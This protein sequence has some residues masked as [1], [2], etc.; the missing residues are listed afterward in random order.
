MFF[1]FPTY[2]LDKYKD[3]RNVEIQIPSGEKFLTKLAITDQEKTKGLSGTKKEQFA[4]NHALLFFYKE[5]SEKSFWMPDTFM[6]LDIIFLDKNFT[7]LKIE[8]NMHAHPGRK[9]LSQIP[10]TPPIFSRHVM[11]IRSDSPLA[12]KLNIGMKLKVISSYSLLQIESKI[13]R[14]K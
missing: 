7:I 1:I 5:S 4:T 11:E 2:A 10:R 13:P 12:N 14:P 9:N 6:N 8:K 3:I